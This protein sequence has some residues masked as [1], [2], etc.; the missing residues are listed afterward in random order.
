MNPKFASTEMDPAS[1]PEPPTLAE[2]A[3]ILR[4]FPVPPPTGFPVWFPE[5]FASFGA[6]S[7]TVKT[8]NPVPPFRV[9]A[10]TAPKPVF[11]YKAVSSIF[12][13]SGT[14]NPMQFVSWG[15]ILPEVCQDAGF[16]FLT[17][18]VLPVFPLPPLSSRAR[19]FP[20]DADLPRS[21]RAARRLLR[22][23]QE[24][25]ARAQGAK[26]RLPYVNGYYLTCWSETKGYL[27][28]RMGES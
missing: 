25:V 11:F 4:E 18:C 20:P 2:L 19:M 8:P 27:S 28:I 7:E 21:P 23:N 17:D 1:I 13:T 14:F 5:S 26:S 24:R 16:R 9:T 3:A 22:R 15:P 10:E 6:G 12:V